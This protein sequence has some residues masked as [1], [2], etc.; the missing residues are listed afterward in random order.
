VSAPDFRKN[1]GCW[2]FEESGTLDHLGFRRDGIAE[3]AIDLQGARKR[4]PPRDDVIAA[5]LA[6]GRGLA[7]AH[8]AGLVHRDFKPNNVLRS[9]DGRVL[10]TDFGLARGLAAEDEL[11][12][13]D[14]P[15]VSLDA[16]VASGHRADSVLH[17]PLT[18]TGAM[19]G[20]PAY[21]APEQYAGAPPDPRT[22]QFAFCVTAWQ[23]LTGARPYHGRTL[24]ELRLAVGAGVDH[25]VTDLPKE[26]RA[27]LVRGLDPDPAKRWPDLEA[28]LAAFAAAATPRRRIAPFVIAGAAVVAIAAIAIVAT[29]GGGTEA[30]PVCESGAAVFGDDK[31]PA[32]PAMSVAREWGSRPSG[33]RSKP[34]M[35]VRCFGTVR[36]T[37]VMEPGEWDRARAQ[38]GAGWRRPD[39]RWPDGAAGERSG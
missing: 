36:A 10:V 18:K 20:T 2:K 37:V 34:G 11:P 39:R 19:I 33:M 7:A 28:L 16:A 14:A 4:D 17:S 26:L 9:R 22:D 15:A 12:A 32:V 24:D 29:R 3:P 23:A 27:V 1:A 38:P 30:P 25:V 13:G 5:L 21:M 6:A 35:P 31:L 8:A